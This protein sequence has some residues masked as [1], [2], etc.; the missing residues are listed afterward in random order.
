MLR[1]Q[2]EP[3]FC[4]LHID[5]D[6]KKYLDTNEIYHGSTNNLKPLYFN[7]IESD[8]L[9][10]DTTSKIGGKKSLYITPDEQFTV[11]YAVPLPPAGTKWLR[12]SAD[13]VTDDITWDVWKMPQ[14]I[15]QFKQD[16]TIVKTEFIRI[17]RLMSP[18]LKYHL[19]F[20]TKTPK[21][22]FNHIDVFLW[23]A[24]GTSTTYMDNLKV[25]ILE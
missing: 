13:F 1:I 16:N 9:H 11:P 10:I 19:F 20:D 21:K 4:R 17:H 2:I 18:E 15:I 14:Y 22:P 25:E 24:D 6:I 3:T 23:N 8:T 12:I 7:D 5:N